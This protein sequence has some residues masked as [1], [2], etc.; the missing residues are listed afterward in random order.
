[1]R[2]AIDLTGQKFGR[3][4]VLNKD[5]KS[6]K[7]RDRV[8]WKC[9]CSC[10][11]GNITSVS[12][13]HLNSGHTKSCGCLRHKSPPAFKDLAGQ[14]FGRLVV[15]ERAYPENNKY[16]ETF[17]MCDCDCGNT[18]I[19]HAGRLRDGN[20]QSCG[21]YHK[22]MVTGE[23]H[24]NWKGG[25]VEFDCEFCG[26]KIIRSR[27]QYNNGS[28][29]HFCSPQ[30]HDKWRSENIR[31]D[32]IYNYKDGLHLLAKQIRQSLS[33]REWRVKVFQ[34]DSYTCL[35]CGSKVNNSF[36]AHHKKAFSLILEEN[37]ITT[38][39]EAFTCEELWDV[40]NG[41]TLCEECHMM[42]EEAFHTI[43]GTQNF[44]EQDYY[45]WLGFVGIKRVI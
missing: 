24:W 20:T 8:Y 32:K 26:T 35:K 44:T 36:N 40:N 41:D 3:L 16:N 15:R 12:T 33:Y 23:K 38:T 9:Q 5:E 10:D 45:E 37:D 39:E 17:Y 4:T 22:E 18:V 1:M 13:C 14:R 11:M 27:S 30:C 21:C 28:E 2:K 19:V 6:T 29:H 7:E 31:G 42:G 43:Y 25:N 34:K